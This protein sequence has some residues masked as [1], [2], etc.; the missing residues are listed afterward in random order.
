MSLGELLEAWAGQPAI[1]HHCHPLRRWPFQLSAVELRA[2]FSEALDPELAERHVVNTVGYQD[3][4]RRIARA[5]DCDATE[6]AIL[7]SRNAADQDDYA[8]LLLA[9]TVTG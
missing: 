7:A 1:D 4:I 9:R 2:A 6:A 8:R 5:L 3:A